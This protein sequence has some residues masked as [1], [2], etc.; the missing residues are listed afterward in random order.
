LRRGLGGARSARTVHCG[1]DRH[2]CPPGALRRGQRPVPRPMPRATVHRRAACTEE[3][4]MGQRLRIAV[5]GATAAD[6]LAVAES[7][8][9]WNLDGVVLGDLDPAAANADDS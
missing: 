9:R 7:A 6:L 4:V 8:E 3:F 5:P 2:P 1:R